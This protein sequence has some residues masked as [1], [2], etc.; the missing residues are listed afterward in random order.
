[1]KSTD[2][3]SPA[4]D[5]LRPNAAGIDIASQMHYVAVPSDR[6][7]QSVRKFGGFTE[8]L[9]EM[10]RWLKSCNIDTV[11]MESTGV[12]WIQPF[13][14]LEEY[15]FD[16]FLVNAR[17]IKN[18]SGCKS[19]VKDCQWIQQLHSYGLLNKSFQ[20]DDLIR[21]LR[22]YVRQRKNLTQGYST[23]VQLMQKAFDQMNI[24]LHNV[25]SD[26]TGKSGLLM[27]DAI[28]NGE[29]DANVLAQLG[30]SRIK[31]PQED[32]VKSLQGIWRQDNLFELKQAYE[33]YQVFRDKIADCDKQ[34]EFVLA[35]IAKTTISTEQKPKD[36]QKGNSKRKA[37]GKNK[38]TFNA[39]SYLN[40]I[41]GVDLT[42]IFGISE[43]T[44]TEIISEIGTDMSKWATEKNFTSWLNLAPNT[45]TSGGKRLKSKPMKKKNKA[46][47]AFIL[48]AST[49]KA[50]NNWL[51]EFYRRIKAKSGS[52]AA[53]KATARKL[54]I[55]FYKMMKDKVDFN[56]LPLEEY[57]QYFKERKIKYINKQ[58]TNYGFKLVPVDFVS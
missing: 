50:S 14:V 58:A 23:Q 32:I 43:L 54:A 40:D 19:D 9:H 26:I 20:P 11:A 31:A 5:L 42:D 8:D 46:G 22:T 4:F 6:D 7:E 29:R 18:V 17:H 57:N 24:K 51:G 36:N 35:K 41:S 33:I 16:V 45:R 55:I 1:M 2:L 13:L 56:P 28:L 3:S 27:I 34:I 53:I 30:D 52:P 25:I 15:G 21:E 10:A 12:Y 47:Q 44:V 48:A 49:L 39:T 38:F 37:N